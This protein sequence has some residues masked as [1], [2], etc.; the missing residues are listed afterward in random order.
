MELG[1][2]DESG[3]RRPVVMDGYNF[4]LK[5]DTLI[6][7]INQI[8]EHTAIKGK[9]FK[10]IGWGTC[11]TNPETLQISVGW[12]FA[13][14]DDVLGAQTIAKAVYQGRVATEYLSFF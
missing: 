11:E 9:R 2:P 6:P 5:V 4:K 14:G 12:F 3:R 10:M 1:E 8:V 13:G 7:A